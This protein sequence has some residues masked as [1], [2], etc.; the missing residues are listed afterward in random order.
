VDQIL[1]RQ[2]DAVEPIW[3]DVVGQHAARRVHSDQQIQSFALYVLKGVT[4]A[5]L[6]QTADRKRKPKQLQ[7]KS[8]D[9][10][11]PI[12]RS[13][14]LRQ[15][16]RGNKLLQPLQS[17]MFRAHEERNQER[18]KQQSPKPFWCAEGHG[19]FPPS[20]RAKSRNPEA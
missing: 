9:A 8:Y 4:P 2:F 3:L 16:A 1:N 13:G 19:T 11:P 5:R 20:F 14:K 12:D 17:T 6:R 15:Q 10:P 7:T 18:D